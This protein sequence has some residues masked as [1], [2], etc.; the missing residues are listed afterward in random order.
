MYDE[1]TEDKFKDKDGKLIVN[2]A[3]FFGYLVLVG[4]S[5]E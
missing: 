5:A 1:M 2:I 4:Y 3:G